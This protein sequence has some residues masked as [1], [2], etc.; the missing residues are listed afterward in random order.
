MPELPEV[1]TVKIGLSELIIGRRIESVELR[2]PG[3]IRGLGVAEFTGALTGATFTGID[4]R[5]KM[6]IIR[7]SAGDLI[8][9]L[10]MSGRFIYC[11][12]NCIDER[13]ARAIFHL[14]NGYQLRFADMR[15]FGFFRLVTGGAQPAPELSGLGPEPLDLSLK[16]F[17]EMVFA[18]SG[19]A[20]PIK[21][22]LMD[23]SF[24]SGIGNLYADE[25]L[26]AAK[27]HPARRA[28]SLTGEEVV[29]L[30]RQIKRVLLKAIDNR[31]TTFDLYVDAEGRQG[32]H[33]YEL[34]VYRRAGKACSRCGAKIEKV[35]MGGRGTHFCPVCQER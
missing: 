4:R 20:R 9:H 26:F 34:K 11:Q 19:S 31:G 6:L 13:H 8:V 27:I 28:G 14:D 10:K 33:Q 12:N 17:K 35:K 3:L 22:I 18:K 23:Q 1:E 7:T 21:L 15:K 2:F 16:Q 32:G 5:A 25:I 24:I 29:E 30:Y